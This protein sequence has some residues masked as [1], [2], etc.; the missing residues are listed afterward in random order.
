[1]L[2][3][4]ISTKQHGVTHPP[5]TAI[6]PMPVLSLLR[7][8]VYIKQRKTTLL[9]SFL[10]VTFLDLIFRVCSIVSHDFNL[11]NS[12]TDIKQRLQ[13]RGWVGVRVAAVL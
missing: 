6:R 13:C 5:P 9:L 8:N 7:K 3:P 10:V 12:S 2:V 4:Y 11:D 1:M